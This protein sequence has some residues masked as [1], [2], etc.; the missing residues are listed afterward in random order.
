MAI[1]IEITKEEKEDIYIALSIRCGF[2]ETG[3]INRAVDLANCEKKEKIKVLSREQRLKI[4]E[5]E[6][7]MNKIIQS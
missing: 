3:T 4:V 1:K 7:L 2:I 6:N 5:I